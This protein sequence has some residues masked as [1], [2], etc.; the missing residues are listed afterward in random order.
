MEQFLHNIAHL[1]FYQA[2]AIVVGIFLSDFVVGVI[3]AVSSGRH[4]KSHIMAACQDRKMQSFFKYI[5]MAVGFH[6][7][8]ILGSYMGI[9]ETM[10]LSAIGTVIIAIPAVPE[11]L[12]IFENAKIIRTGIDTKP[13]TKED[14]KEDTKKRNGKL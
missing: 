11:L 8:A 14:S 6:L 3:A 5:I 13:K 10:S 4:I 2:L 7:A 1:H 9:A 12:S